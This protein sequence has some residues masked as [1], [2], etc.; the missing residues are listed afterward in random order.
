VGFFLA[1]IHGNGRM[2]VY[3]N[4]TQPPTEV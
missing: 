3:K 2:R 4:S 1:K